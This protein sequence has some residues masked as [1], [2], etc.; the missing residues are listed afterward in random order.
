MHKHK[1]EY[2]WEEVLEKLWVRVKYCKCG[3]TIFLWKELL[4]AMRGE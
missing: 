4:D 3:E 2:R 1:W